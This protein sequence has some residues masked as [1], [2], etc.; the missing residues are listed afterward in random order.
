[1]MHDEAHF[2]LDGY[3]N[4]Q[5]CRFWAVENPRELHQRPLHT[6]KVSVWCGILKVEIAGPYFFEEEGATVTS[7]RYVEM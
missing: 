2:H 3:V 4:K 1:M 7:E 5:N 6:A